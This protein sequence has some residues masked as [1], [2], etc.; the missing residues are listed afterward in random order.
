L[1]G[2]CPEGKTGF[3]AKAKIRRRDSLSIRDFAGDRNV[4][5]GVDTHLSS[6]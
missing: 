1:G 5:T 4:L 3:E 6:V 2:R